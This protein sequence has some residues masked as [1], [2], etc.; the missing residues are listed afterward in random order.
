MGKLIIAGGSGSLG[1]RLIAY[2]SDSFDDIVILT[3]RTPGTHSDHREVQWD[4]Q[5]QGAWCQELESAK[6]VINLSG[7]SIQCRF[8]EANKKALTDSRVLSTRAIGKCIAD[9][10]RP[11]LLWIN[12]SGAAIYPNSLTRPMTEV[13]EEQGEG[14]KA[15]LSVAWEAAA[16]EHKLEHSRQ[17]IMRITPVLDQSSGMYPTLKQLSKYRLGGPAGRGD[18]IVS[19]I[20]HEDF[21]RATRF[22]IEDKRQK[23]VFNLAAPDARPNRSFMRALRKSLNVLIGLP[24]PAFGIKLS[25]YLTGVDPSLILDSSYVYPKRLL[26]A[27]FEFKF[28]NLDDAFEDLA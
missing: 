20:H 27:G 13:V 10:E 6:V 3:R 23:G 26:E 28:N 15:Q 25:Q 2:L 1:Q 14:F 16:M 11:P 9:C 8:T 24:A 5:N 19:W 4:G 12:A 18:Q 7:K 17:V 22:L 21:C